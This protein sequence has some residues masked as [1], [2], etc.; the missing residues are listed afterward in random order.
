[1]PT[2]RRSQTPAANSDRTPDSP[3]ADSGATALLAV[4][5]AAWDSAEKAFRSIAPKVRLPELGGIVGHAPGL[6]GDGVQVL[7]A[8]DRLRAAAGAVGGRLGGAALGAGA[9][10]A[11]AAWFPPAEP[12]A[13]PAGAIAGAVIG[14]AGMRARTTMPGRMP[15]MW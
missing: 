3:W 1:M 9:G 2:D 4:P 8:K 15:A 12:I 14:D 13:V 6:L 5:D 7:A 11:A 10:A